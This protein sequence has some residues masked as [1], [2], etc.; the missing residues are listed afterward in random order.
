MPLCRTFWML[1]AAGLWFATGYDPAARAQQTTPGQETKQGQTQGQAPGQRLSIELAT[2]GIGNQ[3]KAGFWAPIWL[4]IKAGPQGARGQLEIV[5]PDGDGV[6]VVF[7][8]SKDT[9][10]DLSAGEQLSLLRYAKI[11]PVAAP[12]TVRLRGPS[13]T[14]WSLAL[15][16][17]PSRLKATQELVVGIGPAVGLPEAIAT[18]RRA[19]E[20]RL[21]SVQIERA[22]DLPDRWWGYEGVDAVVL[23][24]GDTKIIDAMTEAQTAAL[25]QWVQL[26]GRMILS[27]GSQGE[28]VLAADGPWAAVAP[29]KLLEVS[30]LRDRA[31]LESFVGA[32]LPDDEVFQRSRPLVTR[33]A[34]FDG[35][36]LVDELASGSNRPLVI[37]SAHG[38]GEVIFVGLDLDHPALANWPGRTRLV[39]SLLTANRQ[40]GGEPEVEASRSI[41]HLGYEDLVGQ[42]RVGLDQFAGVKL[43]NFTTVAVLC[44]AYLLLVG[45]ADYLLLSQLGLP[46]H[47]TWGTFGLIAV[48]FGVGAWYLGRESHGDRFRAN[49]VEIIDIDVE[50]RLVRGTVWTHLY[51]PRTVQ[52]DLQ[53]AVSPERL[54]LEQTAGWL[55]WQGLPG[56][57]LG[58][59]D[60]RQV[61]LAA[62]QAYRLNGPSEQAGLQG[63]PIHNASSKSLS[64]V[65]W[66]TVQQ[67]IPS[68]L[69]QTE[70]GPPTGELT[71]PLPVELSDCLLVYRDWLFRLGTLPA[72]ETIAIDPRDSLNL[73]YRLTERTIVGDKDVSTRWDQA[74][75]DIPRIARMLMFHEAARG[76]TYTGLTSRYQAKLDLSD[77][78]RL[79]RAVLVGRAAQGA[80][81]LTDAGQPVVRPEDAATWT[82]CRIVLPVQ[83]PAQPTT[84]P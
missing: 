69:R 24:T 26:G 55:A 16:G 15:A 83:P 36:V 79:G 11:G 78:V 46:R 7:S 39:A 82:W 80:T 33:L 19:P 9:A 47:W 54:G 4:R 84:T 23:T 37:R 25:V 61:S 57:S 63:V 1:V 74:S 21:A 8:D 44:V 75:T 38:L 41:T 77:H 59:L 72:G 17:L 81:V 48:G 73:E 45:P 6:P 70:F 12:I 66:G 27:V 50:Q 65:W 14:L 35:V 42:L 58:G 49:Q 71:N 28:R 40:R 31:G 10:I 30:P 76:Q 60:S 62:A 13:Q 52:V 20:L 18:L 22:A 68:Q 2:V 3:C 67:S 32:D 56:S 51:S 34:E 53:L 5:V 29:G 64:A 43:V